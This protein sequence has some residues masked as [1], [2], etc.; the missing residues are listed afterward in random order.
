MKLDKGKNTKRGIAYGLMNKLA[1]LTLPFLVQT[2]LI[3]TLG[4]E[5]VGVK[6]LFSSI[7]S[8]LSLTELGV[9]SAIVYSMY[10]PIAE[11]DTQTIGALLNLYRRLYRV[12]GLIVLLLGLIIMPFLD[13]LIDEKAPNSINLQAIFFLYLFNTVISYWMYAYKS[14]LLNAYQRIDVI[15]IIGTI[16]QTLTYF[17]QIVFLLV[18]KNFYVFLIITIFFTVV[19]NLITSKCVDRMYPEIKCE[20]EIALTLKKNIKLNVSG[21][22]IGKIC[23]TTR[24]TFD[25]IFM[26]VFLGLTQVAIYS[27]YYYILGALNGVATIILSSLLAGIGNSIAIESKEA[28]FRQMMI[29]NTAY[30]MISGWMAVCM[31]C[32]YQPF[33]QLWVGKDLLFPESVMILFPIYFYVMKLGDI[34][35]VYSDAAGLF[36]ENRYRNLI[37]AIANVVLNCFFVIQL[38]V[39]GIMLATIITLFFI[40]FLG[41]AIVIFKNYFGYG[42]KEYLLNSGFYAMATVITGIISYYICDKMVYSSSLCVFFMRAFFCVSITPCILFIIVCKR[43]DFR[44][45]CKWFRKVICKK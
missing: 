19:N 27:N 44:E 24:N 15:S 1:T 10:K 11:D 14:S 3:K 26:S 32:L 37:E 35:G 30:M 18:S 9:G 28:N 42:L 7:L 6:G 36:W 2:I 22:L 38:G 4:V 45:T 40:G 23:G 25:N 29:I 20:G 17:F 12:I 13:L 21:L 43:K 41:S 39:F 34:R 5:Y 16:T 31:L 33:I 8:V